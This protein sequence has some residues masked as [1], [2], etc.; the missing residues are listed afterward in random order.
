MLEKQDAGCGSKVWC[1]VGLRPLVGEVKLMGLLKIFKNG[2]L[3]QVKNTWLTAGK[4]KTAQGAAVG[5]FL[6]FNKM[7]FF[8]AGPISLHVANI[9]KIAGG[10]GAEDYVTFQANYP[11]SSGGTKTITQINFGYDLGGGGEAIYC[12]VTGLS[13]PVLDGETIR[14]QWVLTMAYSS[15]GVTSTYRNLLARMLYIGTMPVPLMIDFQDTGAGSNGESASLEEGGTGAEAYHQWVAT[16]TAPGGG[17]II[18]I[19][20]LNKTSCTPGNEYVEEDITDKTLSEGDTLTAHI[21]ITH[22]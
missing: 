2:K 3:E 19:I 21:K 12:Q 8:E 22:S 9:T 1:D 4:N 15:G 14:Y 13:V 18:D 16:Y 5:T 20:I 6:A 17:K 10:T 11:N 7:E